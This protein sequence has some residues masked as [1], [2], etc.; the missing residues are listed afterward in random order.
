MQ[1]MSSEAERR[2]RL[3]SVAVDF[4]FI[5]NQAAT[6][7]PKPS[8]RVLE[9]QLTSQLSSAVFKSVDI[10]ED[11]WGQV[12]V[13][14]EDDSEDNVMLVSNVGFMIQPKPKWVSA[15]SG[16]ASD[17][18]LVEDLR[19][20]DDRT[21][22]R[23]DRSK[24]SRVWDDEEDEQEERD[25][26]GVNV[27]DGLQVEI[28]DMTSSP[29]VDQGVE[30]VPSLFSVALVEE[31]A[32]NKPPRELRVVTRVSDRTLLQSICVDGA[33]IMT[34][35]PSSAQ[36]SSS[37]IEG[38]LPACAMVIPHPGECP[39]SPDDYRRPLPPRGPVPYR[40]WVYG[41]ERDRAVDRLLS[42]RQLKR[43]PGLWRKKS[44][45]LPPMLEVTPK[46]R[47]I[48]ADIPVKAVDPPAPAPAPEPAAAVV[49]R[50]HVEAAAVS[51]QAKGKKLPKNLLLM[52][53]KAPK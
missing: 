46:R 44:R 20:F 45:E 36:L 31:R 10:G 17:A 29:D 43:H 25:E 16:V 41:E 6:S 49:V 11:T 2:A 52:L 18:A 38:L 47:H 26:D 48:E 7:I 21:T 53:Q 37:E 40:R 22:E 51:L 3:A 1:K 28:E 33:D 12:S 13:P 30:D 27:L 39:P 19:S 14:D 8:E 32:R 4:S 9:S 5:V 15:P 24:W 50:Q 34:N 42:H 23:V 35:A